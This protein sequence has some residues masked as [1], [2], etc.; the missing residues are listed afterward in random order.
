[1]KATA[2][3]VHSE[4]LP[5]R[6][7]GRRAIFTFYRVRRAC[8]CLWATLLLLT[9][10]LA[11]SGCHHAPPE[12]T[13]ASAPLS[14][15]AVRFATYMAIDDIEGGLTGSKS[16]LANTPQGLLSW[17]AIDGMVTASQYEAAYDNNEI[18]ADNQYK[19]KRLLVSGT[20]AKI[21][22]D[23]SGEG[24]IWLSGSGPM[25][26]HAALDAQGTR[27][28]SVFI[29]EQQVNLVCQADGEILTVATLVNCE[30][31]DS[32]LASRIPSIQARI[33][34]FLEGRFALPAAAGQIIAMAYATGTVLPGD[35]PCFRHD[36]KECSAEIDSLLGDTS[37]Q[38]A[39]QAKAQSMLRTL[40]ES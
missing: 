11:L 40:K 23:F 26:I 3:S 13:A 35:S 32:Y 17:A 39:I 18:S 21:Q 25:G 4:P 19:G 37:T 12:L 8:I 38:R 5:N 27:A 10:P 28:A 14:D 15:P 24:N 33:V 36:Q 30:Q 6:P 29:R 2:M 7:A 22:K 20:I 34:A 1:M 31:L 9:A 16:A